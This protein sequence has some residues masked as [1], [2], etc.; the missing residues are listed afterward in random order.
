MKFTILLKRKL[1]K[2]K[3][4]TLT[5]SHEELASQ[6]NYDNFAFRKTFN[7]VQII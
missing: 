5:I 3:I 1:K 7:A 4:L 2:I 6:K